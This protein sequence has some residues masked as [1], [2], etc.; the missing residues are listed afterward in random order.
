METPLVVG[1]FFVY[2][3]K[4]DYASK[5][6]IIQT[7][8]FLSK[9][10]FIYLWF[11]FERW[12]HLISLETLPPPLI[13]LWHLYPFPAH[14]SVNLSV[15]FLLYFV[16]SHCGRE[17]PRGRLLESR[18]S[19]AVIAHYM[20]FFSHSVT[21]SQLVL[22]LSHPV[23]EPTSLTANWVPDKYNMHTTQSFDRY[24]GLFK[25]MKETAQCD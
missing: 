10:L 13:S 22:S 17:D 19:C 3:K 8:H 18:S 11:F 16:F 24:H 14:Q 12:N 1:Q 9:D 23:S 2:V 6:H 25:P 21:R 20:L 15:W 7:R 5:T 4:K